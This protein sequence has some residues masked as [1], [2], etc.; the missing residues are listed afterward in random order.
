MGSVTKVDSF[1]VLIENRQ[2][3]GVDPPNF[4]PVIKTGGQV[5][6]GPLYNFGKGFSEQALLPDASKPI[7]ATHISHNQ[8]GYLLSLAP[9]AG[10]DGIGPIEAGTAPVAFKNG[11][12][13]DIAQFTICANGKF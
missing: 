3:A 7:W 4:S 9:S 11:Q 8:T 13:V 5:S 1:K 12:K 6:Y 2:N 10:N